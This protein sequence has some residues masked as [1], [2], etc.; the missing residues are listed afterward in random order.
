MTSGHT[1]CAA[2]CAAER[3]GTGSEELVKLMRLWSQM[4]GHSVCGAGHS[5]AV[6]GL[7]CF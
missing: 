2:A 4:L 1:M 5:E 6:Q 7:V 3:R